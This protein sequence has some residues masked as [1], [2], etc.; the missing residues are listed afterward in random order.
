M[1]K[2]TCHLLTRKS[3]FWKLSPVMC[4]EAVRVKDTSVKNAYAMK[5]ALKTV[6]RNYEERQCASRLLAPKKCQIKVR[7]NT[8]AVHKMA[9]LNQ[10]EKSRRPSRKKLRPF[11]GNISPAGKTP[12]VSQGAHLH[13]NR[14]WQSLNARSFPGCFKNPFFMVCTALSARPLEAA[15]KGCVV[16][17][18]EH[19]CPVNEF[20]VQRMNIN[21]CT[22]RI[23][24]NEK[25][26]APEWPEV[27]FMYPR[28]WGFG[29]G[30]WPQGHLWRVFWTAW[31]VGQRDTV[32]SISLS[33]FGHNIATRIAIW[34]GNR[35]I[36]PHLNGNPLSQYIS[37]TD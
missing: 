20:L 29:P 37:L 23:Y 16:K 1:R 5:L 18:L 15:W 14:N 8:E 6:C 26:L 13:V 31:H 17:C 10:I 28:P 7:W 11:V 27:I 36:F 32:S 9:S 33:M 35:S 2:G 30:P 4:I 25:H 34:T 22:V 21:P 19:Y 24:H 12:V 3:Y